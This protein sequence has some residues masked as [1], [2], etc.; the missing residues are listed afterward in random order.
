MGSLRRRALIFLIC[1]AVLTVWT[2]NVSAHRRPGLSLVHVAP[3]PSAPPPAP[4][5]DAAPG[6]L[7]LKPEAYW[8]RFLAQEQAGDYQEALKTG[9]ALVNLFPQAPQR[10]IALLKLGDLA[11]GEGKTT[12]ALELYG[13]VNA[14][15]PGTPEASQACLAAGALELNHDLHQGQPVQA[16]RRFLERVAGLPAS[17]SPE[18]LKEALR[19]GWQSVARQVQATDPPPLPLV[20]EILTLWD[21]QPQ[22][23]VPPEAAQL[24]ADLLKRNGLVEEAQALLPKT[25]ESHRGLQQKMLKA[26]GVEEPFLSRGC[27]DSAQT[28]SLASKGSLEQK[29]LPPPRLPDWQAG[30]EPAPGPGEALAAR[31]LPQKANA[32]RQDGP[33]PPLGSTLL[34]S[35]PASV[36]LPP[37][38]EAAAASQPAG[39]VSSSPTGQPAPAGTVTGEGPF[40]QDR[41]GLNHVQEGQPEAA[42]AAFQELAQHR[43]P[44]WQRLAK[45]RLADLDLARLQ[46]EPAP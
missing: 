35:R 28:L 27:Q 8:K 6:P 17:Y 26:Y 18:T 9:L 41:L 43:D 14:V 36:P 30:R 44:F 25:N 21:L 3:P 29:S 32:A 37:Q 46:A 38:T 5:E 19:T 31:F 1:L 12:A 7:S 33:Q 13:L 42:Q 11:R 15:A 39:S 22:S 20:E 16:L 34:Y 23:L 10:G 24:M 2:G 4:E 40:F 45:V